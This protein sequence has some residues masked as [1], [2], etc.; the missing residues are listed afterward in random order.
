MHLFAFVTIH[1]LNLHQIYWRE[2]ILW[3]YVLIIMI[4]SLYGTLEKLSCASNRCDLYVILFY[5]FEFTCFERRHLKRKCLDL[6]HTHSNVKW[7]WNAIML[8]CPLRSIR[9][10]NRVS[11]LAQVQSNILSN[12]VT[13]CHFHL[14][15]HD[16]FLSHF[17]LYIS[18]KFTLPARII[19]AVPYQAE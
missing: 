10:W 17:L 13:C 2:V 3:K 14:Q 6:Y 5:V 11:P 16:T 1:F 15:F 12:S 9:A 4:V 8:P 7:K 19:K 18:V